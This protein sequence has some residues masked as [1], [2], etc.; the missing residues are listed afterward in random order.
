MAQPG[1]KTKGTAKQ[2][3]VDGQI[4]RLLVLVLFVASFCLFAITS[5]PSIGW[6]DSPEFVAQAVS[7]GIAHS[8][9]HPLPALLGRF[10][11]LI[12]VGDIVWR[13]NLMSSLCAA[14]SISLLFLCGITLLSPSPPRRHIGHRYLMA[15]VFACIVAV[16]WAFWS[17]AVRAEVY[18]LQALLSL[19]ALF[20]VLQYLRTT[21]PQDLL[22]A[23]FI[24]ALGLAN[25]HLLTLVLFLPSAGIII[26]GK[27]R[28]SLR[29]SM[30]SAALGMVGLCALLYLPI[31]SLTHPL[32]NFGAPHT[33]ERFAW[34][35]SGAAFSKSVS[36]SH[37]A[38]PLHDFFDIL[39]ALSSA[40][41][42]PLLLMGVAGGLLALRSWRTQPAGILLVTI[43]V[44]CVGVRVL[45]GFDSGTSDHH[46]YLFPA[47]AA[48]AMLA[49]LALVRLC[50]LALHAKRPLPNAPAIATFALA[51]IVPITLYSNWG[52][53]SSSHAYVSDDVAHW[54]IE[55]LPPYS[56]VLTA[57]FQTTFRQWALSVVEGT[58]PDIVLLDR[59]FLSYPGMDEE[60]K[61]RNP[62]LSALIDSPLRPGFASPLPLIRQIA[63]QRPVYVQAH[64]NVDQA[65][66]SSI[67]PATAFAAFGGS[68]DKQFQASDLLKRAE[69]AAIVERAGEP[70]RHEA[71]GTLLWHDAM[72]L[73]LLCS[74]GEREFARLVLIDAQ[75]I[76]PHDEMLKEMAIRCGLTN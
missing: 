75:T 69:L 21:R 25:H 11:S 13:V 35:L 26:V 3:P 68:P 30:H 18:A 71:V 67:R 33:L 63:S 28:P 48:T 74:L 50:D 73:D 20:F 12:P 40:L 22:L 65:L 59:S 36:T 4:S 39:V 51:L 23:A 60:A 24:F 45:L 76:A 47:I 2:S 9:G 64:L 16:S 54:E 29:L 8:P 38:P 55:S 15:S 57:Y 19:A 49:L 17:N 62:E 5:S 70:E 10:A 42:L 1:K 66:A 44:L 53:T 6:M 72:R 61:R 32:V 14:A 27:T 31:R 43:A 56:L 34:T 52:R 7:L 41:S 37:T 58:R 46:A